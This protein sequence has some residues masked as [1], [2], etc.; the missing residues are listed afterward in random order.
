MG[1][2]NRLLLD[3]TITPHL[4]SNIWQLPAPVLSYGCTFPPA[5]VP[6]HWTMPITFV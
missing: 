5:D 6:R 1:N 3:K 4:C 2:G